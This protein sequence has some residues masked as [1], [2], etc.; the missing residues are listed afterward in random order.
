MAGGRSVHGTECRTHVRHLNGSVA[1][2]ISLA[3]SV[4]RA[5]RAASGVIAGS[6]VVG[7][8]V[9]VVWALV[10][11]GEQLVMLGS[12]R[13]AILPGEDVHRFDAA[14]MFACLG[15]AVGTLTAAAAWTARASRGVVLL[16]AIVVG[17]SLGTAASAVVGLGVQGLRFADASEVQASQ[18]VATAP[19]LATWWMLLFA[20]LSAAVVV[21]VLA[22]L[23]PRDD[24]GVGDSDDPADEGAA[25]SLPGEPTNQVGGRS[26]ANSSVTRNA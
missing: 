25:E 21:A 16:A 4:R 11:P 15:V 8:A 9:G 5:Q 7:V 10:V 24:L 1:Q 26:A 19:G 12:G 22:L 14:A 18:I 13:L 2:V 3:G 6:L 23:S 20:P 17:A